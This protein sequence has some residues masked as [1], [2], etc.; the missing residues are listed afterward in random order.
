MLDQPT[1]P[2]ATKNQSP[3]QALA[4]APLPISSMPSLH[5]GV[6]GC[7]HWGKNLIRNFAQLQAGLTLCDLSPD[8]AADL[9]AQYPG[10]T[11]E[12]FA[13]ALLARPQVQAIVIATP[14]AT[15][16]ALAQKALMLGKHVYIEKP[17]ATQASQVLELQALAESQ[18][19]VLMVGHLLLY[20][21]AVNRLR[22]VIQSGELG[23]I[24][25]ICSERMNFN[26]ARPDASVLWDLA[27]H[28]ISLMQYLLDAE[29]TSV[30]D[31][32]GHQVGPDGK[33]DFATLHMH[34]GP[35]TVCPQG[36]IGRV[37]NS[38]V[39][40]FKQVQLMVSGTLATA[41]LDDT[42]TAG[43]LRV[44][45]RN[46]PLDKTTGIGMPE[47]ETIDYL[48][49]EPLKLECQH[50]LH[51]VHHGWTPK[52]DGDNGLAVVRILEQAHHLLAE[53]L[54]PAQAS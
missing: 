9:A 27:P 10:V 51:A 1:P 46:S 15:H 36:V 31:V 23:E 39:H 52:T 54:G 44:F 53:T 12:T 6:L 16:Y 24:R 50:F 38:W 34:F 22:Q 33:V 49:L 13:D 37:V 17:L 48:P 40:P 4:Q 20:H 21:P 25:A 47:A 41:V 14:S 45:R 7:G 30:K 32:T 42:L 2:T 11:I 35:G 5:L 19:C 8:R 3:G 43:K 29:P 28:D 26:A 18:G